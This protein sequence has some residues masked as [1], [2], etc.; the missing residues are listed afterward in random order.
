MNSDLTA[1]PPAI[2]FKKPAVRDIAEILPLLDVATFCDAS[3]AR[4]KVFA[5]FGLL[6]GLEAYKLE[7][8]TAKRW[9]IFT[10]TSRF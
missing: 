3:D 4:D 6:T 8:D 10:W 1:L 9:T 7:A 2:R 5:L